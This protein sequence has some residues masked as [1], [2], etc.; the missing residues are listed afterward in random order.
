[1][2]EDQFEQLEKNIASIQ[3]TIAMETAE[4]EEDLSDLIDRLR[5]FDNLE[6]AVEVQVEFA[7]MTFSQEDYDDMV[8][9][10]QEAN[11]KITEIEQEAGEKRIDIN[12]DY[13]DDIEDLHEAHLDRRLDLWQD[14][15]QRLVDIGTKE[16]QNTAD[17]IRKYQFRIADAE[18]DA[19]FRRQ[20][21]E[22]KYRE[23]ELKEER[24]F[25]EKL[26]QL[27]ENFLFDLED[28]V[29]ERD[30]RQII[31][32]TR[33]YNMRRD[34]LIREEKIAKD[35]RQSA[36]EEELRQIE[37][38]RQQ[39][40]QQLAIEHQRRLE[41][42]AIQAERERAQAALDYE[43]KKQ[44]EAERYEE[45]KEKREERLQEQLDKLDED[46]QKRVNK[47]IESL[48]KEYEATRAWLN[49]IAQL[50]ENTYGPNSRIDNA[51]VWY[52]RR[53]QQT[54][55]LQQ[56]L[57]LMQHIGS[58]PGGSPGAFKEMEYAGERARGGTIVADKP[59]VAI[60]GEAGPEV[61]T[62]TP[63]NKIAGQSDMGGQ[64]PMG[65]RD[66]LTGKLRIEM[67]LSPD[68]ETNI[69]DS[70]LNEGADVIY[71]IERERR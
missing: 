57:K 37:F 41:E 29:R 62:F 19:A 39:R 58:Y 32:L 56:K 63:L 64:I 21:A 16:S 46:T 31:R 10:V 40:L 24:K 53:L 3:S 36:F 4:M 49:P 45:D 60:F 61:A 15:Q 17:E 30:A 1:M 23:R 33:Q 8:K 22:R 54:W 18:R 20:E 55:L 6:P 68:L 38:Q 43:R 28:A 69:I 5:T 26:R 70:A 51:L 13:L 25:Q 52:Q 66:P 65:A 44:E 35:D 12:E 34:Q 14:Y 50:Y 59:T 9:I 47:I 48:M 11:E 7:G 71:T 42:I 2:P 67:M 27:R